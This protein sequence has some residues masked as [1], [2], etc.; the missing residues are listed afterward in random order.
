[1]PVA[2][3]DTIRPPLRAQRVR[4]Q[5]AAFGMSDP[6]AGYAYV[7]PSGGDTP[8]LWSLTWRLPVAE[9]QLF[10]QWFVYETERGTIPFT[11]EL[12]TEFGLTEYVCSFLPGGLLDA[13]EEGELWVYSATVEARA[14]I[15]PEA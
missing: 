14:R 5:G 3:P 10:M 7:Q 11:I 1:M 4:S 12:R 13:R 6:R 9:A 2:Y 15:V 8:V